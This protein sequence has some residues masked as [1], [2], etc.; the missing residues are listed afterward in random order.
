MAPR[1]EEAY[2]P[3]EIVR[4]VGVLQ[5]STSRKQEVVVFIEVV[6][7]PEVEPR[8]VVSINRVSGLM[9]YFPA[10]R[11]FVCHFPLEQ[12][13]GEPI[14]L[15]GYAALVDPITAT[16]IDSPIAEALLKPHWKKH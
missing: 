11:K 5:A 15:V 2:I 1:S 8:A 4:R 16:A 13:T 3:G 9:E 7:G 10:D 6:D 12:Q 14:I